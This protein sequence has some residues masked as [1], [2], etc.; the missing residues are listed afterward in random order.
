MIEAS[1]L[2]ISVHS[3]LVGLSEISACFKRKTAQLH[4]WMWPLGLV[5]TI[6]QLIQQLK[7]TQ[8]TIT[9]QKRKRPRKPSLQPV[10]RHS[11]NQSPPKQNSQTTGPC[12][13]T[14]SPIPVRRWTMQA[15]IARRVGSMIWSALPW[16]GRP[17][18]TVTWKTFST[19]TRALP[20]ECKF[21]NLHYS[22]ILWW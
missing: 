10:M 21:T 18:L 6:W 2:S 15:A 16:R 17:F 3:C 14:M 13:N 5:L 22:F 4:D 9:T 11:T 8:Q 12:G 7:K 1:Y 20:L 19:T